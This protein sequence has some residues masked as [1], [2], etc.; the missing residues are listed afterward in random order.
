MVLFQVL[1]LIGTNQLFYLVDPLVTNLPKS[2]SQIA[3]VST[4]KY[5]GVQVTSQ[6]N[7]YWR[8]IFPYCLSGLSKVWKIWSK[9][10]LTIIGRANLIKMIWMPQLLYLLHNCPV[11]FPQ[12]FF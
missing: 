12:K 3:V 5:F 6:V 9:I 10:P 1:Q 2:A 11:W 7:T 4:F 8:E